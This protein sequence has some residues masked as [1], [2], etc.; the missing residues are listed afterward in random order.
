MG[1]PD[2]DITLILKVIAGVG[3]GGLTI[4]FILAYF[5]LN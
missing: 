1:I 3:I 2:Q 5:L 4:G